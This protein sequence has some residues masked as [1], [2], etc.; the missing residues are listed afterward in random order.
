MSITRIQSILENVSKCDAWALQL[1]QMRTSKKL[2]TVYSS[3]SIY[4]TPQGKLTDFVVN[5]SGSYL[6]EEKNG[7]KSFYSVLDYDGTAEGNVIYKLSGDNP[8]IAEEYKLLIEALANSEEE[9]DPLSL[10][11]QAY[12]IQGEV[13]IDGEKVSVKLISIQNPITT[14]KHKFI[15]DKNTF[16]QIE[17][18]ILNLRPAI[19]V[20]IADCMVYFFT[21][22]GEKL[23]NME[24]A[25]KAICNDKVTMLKQ[26]KIMADSAIF[27]SVAQ[28]GHHPRMFVSFNEERFHRLK[29]AKERRYFAEVFQLQIKDGKFVIAKEEDADK[30]VKLLCNKG[31]VDPFEDLPVEVS[32]VRKW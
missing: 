28:T 3:S 20:L 21:M 4:L 15:Y 26:S 1:L 8:L 7:L 24:R 31:M 5:L 16:R 14:L 18:K 2:G 27:V 13:S 30:L 23:F 25:Y 10:K 17:N 32:G 22:A 29:S 11:A 19:D 9:D 12:V 6:N